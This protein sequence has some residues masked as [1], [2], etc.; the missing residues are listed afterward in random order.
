VKKSACWLF[1]KIL[2]VYANPNFLCCLRC[3]ILSLWLP[4]DQVLFFFKLCSSPPIYYYAFKVQ[5]E[6]GFPKITLD[7]S[8][9]ANIHKLIR[10]K[11][12]PVD[13][14]SFKMVLWLSLAVLV[15]QTFGQGVFQSKN[16]PFGGDI[17]S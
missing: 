13:R 3:G 12:A 6:K 10:F 1:R 14:R 16:K 7:F 8:R 2:W 9:E 15:S 4:K 17:S 5:E 11:L